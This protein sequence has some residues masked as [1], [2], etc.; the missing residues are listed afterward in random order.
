MGQAESGTLTKGQ[1]LHAGSRTVVS[2]L[3]TLQLCI[4]L[5]NATAAPLQSRPLSGIH[6]TDGVRASSATESTTELALDAPQNSNAE[7]SLTTRI[8]VGKQSYLNETRAGLNLPLLS[9][10]HAA[11]IP[12]TDLRPLHAEDTSILRP[13][14]SANLCSFITL[15]ACMGRG[16]VTL[17]QPHWYHLQPEPQTQQLS[18]LQ[19]PQQV[20]K[21]Q[22]KQLQASVQ[23]KQPR[24]NLLRDLRVVARALPLPWTLHKVC[25][26]FSSLPTNH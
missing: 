2:C 19:K 25:K 8:H 13:T 6:R 4:L 10:K 15:T 20:P 5:S 9:S 17:A 22:L 26:S 16:Q 1:F 24:P 3:Y 11:M 18:Q 21:L 12:L 23:L 7:S 14:R